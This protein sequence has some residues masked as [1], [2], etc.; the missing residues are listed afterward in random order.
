MEP[1]WTLEVT[2]RVIS[3]ADKSFQSRESPPAAASSPVWGPEDKAAGFGEICV[4]IP[5]RLLLLPLFLF[6]LS[7]RY[8]RIEL[9]PVQLDAPKSLPIF[10][11]SVRETLPAHISF[12]QA[13]CGSGRVVL[14]PLNQALG[15]VCFFAVSNFAF[16]SI[17]LDFYTNHIF[18]QKLPSVLR[19]FPF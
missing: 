7:F 9:V 19:I 2:R 16:P 3:P 14:M 10:I 13:V 15:Q 8:R 4:E 18:G 6:L 1:G 12:N 11:L 17:A 5:G